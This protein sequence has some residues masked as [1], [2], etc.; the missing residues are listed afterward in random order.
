MPLHVI[1]ALYV[2]QAGW[3]GDKDPT[4]SSELIAELYQAFQ[5]DKLCLQ[6]HR[7]ASNAGR[8]SSVC[9]ESARSFLVT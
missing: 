2:E 4:F 9:L 1:A 7:K 8:L 3:R 5:Y 6:S